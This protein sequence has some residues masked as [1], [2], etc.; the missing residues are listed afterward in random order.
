VRNVRGQNYRKVMQEISPD[1]V[2][3]AKGMIVCAGAFSP[4]MIAEVAR[5]FDIPGKTASEFL[6]HAGVL[7]TGTW[8]RLPKGTKQQIRAIA[9]TKVIAGDF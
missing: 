7:P 4:R 6:E 2:A 1:L 5:E 8:E 9:A 3:R